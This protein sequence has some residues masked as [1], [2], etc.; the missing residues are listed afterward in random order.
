M[1]FCSHAA[2][3]SFFDF[4]CF[5]DSL[6]WFFLKGFPSPFIVHSR[7]CFFIWIQ[8]PFLA[9]GFSFTCGILTLIFC[10]FIWFFFRN[11]FPNSL[12]V[13]SRSCCSFTQWKFFELYL[14][15][16]PAM[17]SDAL[18]RFTFVH[19]AKLKRSNFL[20]DFFLSLTAFARVTLFPT[21]FSQCF[22]KLICVI[23]FWSYVTYL[24]Q[25]MTFEL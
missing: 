25:K 10:F 1:V 21:L 12:I 14:R 3:S 18:F 5:L 2:V 24:T 23:R 7:P 19:T 9:C 4:Y 6:N 13:R 11:D 22:L 17:S 15:N 20:N 8:F 16:C